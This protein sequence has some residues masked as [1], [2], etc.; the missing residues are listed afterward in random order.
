MN[1][2]RKQAVLMSVKSKQI[3]HETGACLCTSNYA[4]VSWSMSCVRN[5]ELA[6]SKVQTVRNLC[7]F[8]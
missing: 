2:Q 3:T 8:H 4:T 5:Q 7:C 6:V 1:L